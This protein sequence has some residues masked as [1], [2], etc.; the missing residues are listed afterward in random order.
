MTH[1]D[2]Q[3][4]RFLETLESFELD[5]ET[6]FCFVADHGEMIGDHHLFCKL[7]PY[8]G[9]TRVPLIL[10]GP[11]ISGIRRGGVCDQVVELR[12]VMPT[13]LDCAGLPVPD[14]VEGRSLLPLARGET[15]EW[16]GYVHGEHVLLGQSFHWVTN[17]HEKYVWLSGSGHEQLFDLD[18]DPQELHD[19]ARDPASGNR[20]ARWRQVLIE[21]LTGREE[22]FT[23]GE[24]LIPGRPVRPCL[25]H[26]RE[27]AGVE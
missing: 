27:Q 23:D 24:R 14:S 12:D 21:E 9:S 8:E 18:R 20:V 22:E 2:H 15:P 6:Y 13:L 3:I 26:L 7:F 19:L 10:K 1:I 17:G 5:K 11:R 4:N 16:R 25:S